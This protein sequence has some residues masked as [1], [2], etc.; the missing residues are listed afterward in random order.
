VALKTGSEL[1]LYLSST[2]YLL[3]VFFSDNYP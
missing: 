2:F 1:M 3:C